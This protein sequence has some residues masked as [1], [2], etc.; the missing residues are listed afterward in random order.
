[1]EVYG[2]KPKMFT[3][4]WWEYFWMYYKWHTLVLIFASVIVGTG[5][6][7]CA[8]SPKYDL[9]TDF[10]SEQTLSEDM[11]SALNELISENIADASGNGKI[12]TFIL[13]LNMRKTDDY[14]TSQTMQTKLFLE[15]SFSES[16]LFIGSKQYIDWLASAE[17]FIPA[18]EYAENADGT[19]VSLAGCEHLEDI[20]I[21]TSD[22]Y[23]A[24]RSIRKNDEKSEFQSAQYENALRFAQYLM[25]AG[26]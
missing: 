23:V 22:L 10:I 3:K 11:Q 20:G 25:S 5:A 9:Q 17:I 24:V 15:Q 18:S 13:H 2:K 26:R 4:A 1:M 14:Q 7:Q 12:E 6:V 16:Y 8:K 19:Y 21:D